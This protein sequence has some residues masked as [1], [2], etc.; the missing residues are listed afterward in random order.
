M[1]LPPP[2]SGERWIDVDLS[3]NTATAMVGD[4]PWHTAYVTTA[5]PGYETPIGEWRIFYRVYNE[6]MTSGPGA[7]EY[8]YVENVLFTQYFTERG[9]ALHFNYWAPDS[10]FGNE[11]TS[12]GCVG[13]RY[14]DAEF[15]WNFASNGT[16]V[17]VHE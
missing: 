12:H 16:R 14:S 11:G 15:F 1:S 2:G 4:T 7:E 8:Y 17:V 3:E 10:V 6:T 13:M 9:H 5:K